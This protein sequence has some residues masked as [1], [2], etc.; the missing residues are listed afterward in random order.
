[1]SVP[2]DDRVE[3]AMDVSRRR[4]RGRRGPFR[5]DRACGEDGIARRQSVTKAFR[6]DRHAVRRI[7]PLAL[8]LGL[9]L[10]A[11]LTMITPTTTAATADDGELGRTTEV[12][13]DGL[14]LRVPADW[15]VHDL[16]AN[17]HTCVRLDRPAVYLGTPGPDQNCPAKLVGRT[18]TLLIQPAGKE[19]IRT[20][21]AEPP[22]ALTPGMAPELEVF[23]GGSGEVNF[24]VADAGLVITATYGESPETIEAILASAS[25]HGPV[26]ETATVEPA[27]A[28]VDGFATSTWLPAASTG[29]ALVGL[30]FDTCAAPSVSTMK[31]WRSS[32]YEAIGIYIGGVNRACPDGNLSPG[33][34]QKVAQ[35]GWSM[36]PIYVGRQ[37]PCAFQSDLGPIRSKNVGAQGRAAAEDAAE[38]AKYF[39]L[40]RGSTIFFDMEG[41][42]DTNSSCN[43]IVLKFLSAWTWRLHQLG[44]LSGVYSSASSGIKQLSRHYDSTDY[45]RPDVIWN[46]RW[47]GDETV[48]DEPYVARSKWSYHQRVK[49]YRGPHDETHGG[50]TINID[51]NVINAALGSPAYTQKV[52]SSSAL[53]AR[54]GPS[55]SHPKVNTLPSG[56]SLHIVCQVAGERVEG[57]PVW[58]RLVDGSYVTD[59]YVNTGSGFSSKISRCRYPY[60][61]KADLRMR[62]GPGTSYKVRGTLPEGSLAWVVCQKKGEKVGPSR[63]WNKVKDGSWVSDWYTMTPG[64]PGF[65]NAIPRC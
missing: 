62:S 40:R 16:D 50:R 11:T 58:N 61:V 23:A 3:T 30:G 24:A 25:Y 28:A 1:M 54:K 53:N 21:G 10:L 27:T 9:A 22:P 45:A 32:S 7:R 59:A 44:Y 52:T 15:A 57:T 65:T 49:Q 6:D 12:A 55:T 5:R 20:F 8:A 51:S 18:E 41:Y 13:Y 31:A 19:P 36:L 34:V 38:R 60:Q 33:W 29:R 43:K 64:R 4:D 35:Q 47:D 46:A 14:V 63:V 42:D 48:W 56:S 17:P 37:A 26:R 2:H 39:G